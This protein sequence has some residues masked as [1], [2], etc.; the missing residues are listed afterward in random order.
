M[1][2]ALS[3][4]NT[5]SSDDH[6]ALRVWLNRRYA[7]FVLNGAPTLAPIARRLPARLG[8]TPEADER[9]SHV[10]VLGLPAL[11]AEAMGQGITERQLG[12]ATEAHFLALLNTCGQTRL[13]SGRLEPHSAEAE[14]LS[15]LSAAR[16]RAFAQLADAGT[17]RWLRFGAADVEVARAVATERRA[18]AGPRVLT[19]RY[20]ECAEGKQAA[21]MPATLALAVA[22][23]ADGEV[24]TAIRDAARQLAL[25][26]Q[27]R[28]DV[29]DWPE[30]HARGA[31][32]AVRLCADAGARTRVDEA[33]E[34]LRSSGV[35]VDLLGSSRA[36][37]MKCASAARSIGARS[38]VG[39]ANEQA[40]FSARLASGEARRFGGAVLWER[41]RRQAVLA[42]RSSGGRAA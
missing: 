31:S 9:W 17:R 7:A 16:D 35:L 27:F 22:S 13:A 6:A 42:R 18:L 19:R 37:F 11:F 12:L 21:A 39:F 1:R 5:R 25:G 4:Q 38:L 29:V 30:D 28:D 34:A 26:F 24:I 8:C 10:Q 41:R 3:T 32:W 14:V 20:R 36:A 33:E 23:G 2:H 15:A 40:S